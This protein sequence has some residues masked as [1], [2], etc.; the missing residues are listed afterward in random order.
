M[1]IENIEMKSWKM[2]VDHGHA[3]AQSHEHWS[4]FALMSLSY[5]V[6]LSTWIT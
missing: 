1:G 4:L 6:L 3:E 5:M 2:Y